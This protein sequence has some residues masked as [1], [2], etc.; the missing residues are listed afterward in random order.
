MGFTLYEVRRVNQ[1][2]PDPFVQRTLDSFWFSEYWQL[3][4][5]AD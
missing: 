2:T 1:E 5:A 4:R 3:S